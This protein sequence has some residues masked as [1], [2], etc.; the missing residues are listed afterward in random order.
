MT[1][2][3]YITVKIHHTKISYIVTRVHTTAVTRTQYVLKKNHWLSSVTAQDFLKNSTYQ[4]NIMQSYVIYYTHFICVSYITH[5]YIYTHSLTH[6]Y[7]PTHCPIFLSYHSYCDCDTVKKN[8]FK[9]SIIIFTL[10][11]LS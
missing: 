9:R 5:S 1:A 3:Q 6:T 4:H 8:D 10:L 11:L 2:T 7:I